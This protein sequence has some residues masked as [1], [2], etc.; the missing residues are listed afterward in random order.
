M[1]FIILSKK[2]IVNVKKGIEIFRSGGFIPLDKIGQKA[3]I[4]I[5]KISL[6]NVRGNSNESYCLLS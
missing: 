5:S 1:V 2:R 6:N 3:F 4:G